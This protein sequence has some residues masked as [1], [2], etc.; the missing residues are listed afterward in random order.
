MDY[1]NKDHKR[2]QAMQQ[3]E[4]NLPGAAASKQLHISRNYLHSR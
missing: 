3:E 4:A 2:N 1:F